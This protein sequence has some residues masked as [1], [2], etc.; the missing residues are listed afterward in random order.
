MLRRVDRAH[1]GAPRP[2]TTALVLR[3]VDSDTMRTWR[4]RSEG[5]LDSAAF[6]DFVCRE[7]SRRCLRAARSKDW[8]RLALCYNGPKALQHGYDQKLAVAYEQ[9]RAVLARAGARGAA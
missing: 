3:V 2:S 4:S 1:T 6:L 9:Y 5:K 8:K 7:P